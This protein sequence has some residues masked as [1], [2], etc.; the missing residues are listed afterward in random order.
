MWSWIYTQDVFE[1]S[2]ELLDLISKTR[3][4]CHLN[5][6]FADINVWIAHPRTL[7]IPQRNS[8][9]TKRNMSASPL[10][11]P[12]QLAIVQHSKWAGHSL[13]TSKFFIKH[14]IRKN[15]KTLEYILTRTCFRLN[16]ITRTFPAMKRYNIWISLFI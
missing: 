5:I 15:I 11:S 3:Q 10:T 14:I 2:D 12:N 9:F 16:H 6:K 8:K 1:I 4:K 7:E 13:A